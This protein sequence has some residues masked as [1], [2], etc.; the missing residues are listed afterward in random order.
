M[1]LTK[2]DIERQRQYRLGTSV[3]SLGDLHERMRCV[4]SLMQKCRA[5]G[6]PLPND[7]EQAIWDLETEVSFY[8]PAKPPYGKRTARLGT[9]RST[10]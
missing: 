5:D 3:N 6:A 2:A 10:R 1:K 8:V 9:L 7:L 4:R